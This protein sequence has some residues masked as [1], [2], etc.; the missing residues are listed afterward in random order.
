MPCGSK[1]HGFKDPLTIKIWQ[2]GNET[3]YIKGNFDN[4]KAAIKTIEFSKAM[5]K[6]DPSIKIIGWG[7]SG[8]AKKNDRNCR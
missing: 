7:D 4:E 1:D 6:K 3:S 5:K 8:W 2:V